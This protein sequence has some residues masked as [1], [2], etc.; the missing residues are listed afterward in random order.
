MS[1]VIQPVFCERNWYIYFLLNIMYVWRLSAVVWFLVLARQSGFVHILRFTLFRQWCSFS[2]I[3]YC[4]SFSEMCKYNNEFLPIRRNHNNNN[5]AWDVGKCPHTA[6]NNQ[7]PHTPPIVGVAHLHL[8]FVRHN[9]T[10]CVHFRAVRVNIFSFRRRSFNNFL[11]I[12]MAKL[13][14]LLIFGASLNL[15]VLPWRSLCRLKIDGSE[16]VWLPV[17]EITNDLH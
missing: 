4:L 10:S 14:F 11:I 2:E 13:L 7:K 16:L 6:T 8:H 5:I 1:R 3:Q 15:L 9:G 12:W 17:N